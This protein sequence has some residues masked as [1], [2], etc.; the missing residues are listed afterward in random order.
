MCKPIFNDS[1]DFELNFGPPD[2]PEW[3]DD[4]PMSV[5]CN[6]GQREHGDIDTQGLDEGAEAAHEPRQVPT[7]QQGSLELEL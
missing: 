3:I 7:L 1:T 4:G 6:G 5:D 2:S